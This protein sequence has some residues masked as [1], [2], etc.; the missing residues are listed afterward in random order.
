MGNGVLIVPPHN[1]QHSLHWYYQIKGYKFELA[2]N[3]TSHNKFHENPSSH[4]W[5]ITC[6]QMGATYQADDIIM[7]AVSPS[8]QWPPNMQTILDNSVIMF[9]LLVVGN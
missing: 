7:Q 6:T 5:V 8:G 9:V 4:S 1:F 3:G 2:S